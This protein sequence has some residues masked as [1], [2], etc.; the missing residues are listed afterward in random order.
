VSLLIDAVRRLT[1]WERLTLS[2]R[3]TF[4]PVASP[5]SIDAR[6]NKWGIGEKFSYEIPKLHLN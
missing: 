4:L 3:D 1:I 6:R 5:V 2:V